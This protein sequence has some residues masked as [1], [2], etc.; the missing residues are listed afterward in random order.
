MPD[1]AFAHD[2]RAALLVVI[3][4]MLMVAV[5]LHHPTLHVGHHPSSEAVAAGV[6]SIAT[7][8]AAFHGSVLG[9]VGAQAIGLVTVAERL[10][11]DRLAVRAGVFAYGM[12]TGLLC[13]AAIVDGFVSPL[14]AQGCAGEASACA[15]SFTASIGFAFAAIQAFTKMG[16]VAQSIALACWSLVFAG[17][18]TGRLRKAGIGGC[19]LASVPPIL[20][21]TLNGPIGPA[22][23][24]R[25]VAP[26]A[27][28]SIGTAT[29]LWC[30]LLAPG[31]RSGD[32]EAQCGFQEGGACK[33]LRPTA[34]ATVI[35]ASPS[36]ASPARHATQ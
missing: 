14:L 7:A 17:T 30:R 6:A 36:P 3:P 25:L 34:P 27:A 24:V 23:L 4:A 11:L 35:D 1:R 9:L 2:R 5:V 16:I 22:E 33:N 19:V 31:S 15:T 18:R 21:A 26:G 20:L 13:L 29:V 28:W 10:G 12:A 32:D 8:N